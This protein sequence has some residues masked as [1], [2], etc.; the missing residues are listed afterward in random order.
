MLTCTERPEPVPSC[1]EVQ[2]V[3]EGRSHDATS[4]STPCS[5]G[6]DMD[7]C[8]WR[9]CWIDSDSIF[10]DFQMAGYQR[11]RAHLRM[12]LHQLQANATEDRKWPSSS[13]ACCCQG[14]LQRFLRCQ[15]LP[16]RLKDHLDG[17]NQILTSASWCGSSFESYLDRSEMRHQHFCP[18]QRLPQLWYQ[19]HRWQQ[20]H[21]K[22]H[23]LSIRPTFSDGKAIGSLHRTDANGS[24]HQ[25]KCCSKRSYHCCHAKLPMVP[26][27]AKSDH[28]WRYTLVRDQSMNLDPYQGIWH[29]LQFLAPLVDPILLDHFTQCRLRPLLI[30]H[31]LPPLHHLH[32]YRHPQV[33]TL[34]WIY[35]HAAVLHLQVHHLLS[36]RSH[37]HS[38]HHRRHRA[39]PTWSPLPSH[40]PQCPDLSGW[41]HLSLCCSLLFSNLKCNYALH[42]HPII[43]WNKQK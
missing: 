23:A 13:W 10:D 33:A 11:S 24:T 5:F 39:A 7:P 6:T 32:R 9:T 2:A 42:S 1:T 22:S 20:R 40:P 15:Q 26:V 18:G 35:Q 34:Y 4:W 29:S 19:T 16:L 27:L 14:R 28:A 3:L 21:P 30:L 37:P 41:W 38:R 25:S 31:P 36:H 43:N 8:H 12:N 17:C